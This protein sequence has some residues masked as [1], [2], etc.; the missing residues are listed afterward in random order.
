MPRPWEILVVG[1]HVALDFVNTVGGLRD[2]DPDHEALESYEDLLVWSRR[3]G[4]LSAPQVR[5]L[6]AAAAGDPSG[7]E[8]ALAQALSRRALIY[9]IF[10]PLADG[11]RP[12]PTLLERLRDFELEA[13]QHARLAPD[14][15]GLRWTWPRAP[16]SLEAPLWPLT[17][18]AID[19]LTEGPLERL[20]VCA[21]CRWLFL[22][23]SRNRSRR[24]CS[25]EECGTAVKK[26]RFTE[27][28]R[29][30]HK[31]REEDTNADHAQQH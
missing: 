13:L 4:S 10:R 23:E 1:G 31:Q 2:K 12:A 18:A 9:D 27:R 15:Q 14:E 7:S 8:R 20:K 5:A 17:H 6:R 24:W 19:L 22:D 11:K 3:V 28:R 21:N 30:R 29:E 26:E 16:G 25:M